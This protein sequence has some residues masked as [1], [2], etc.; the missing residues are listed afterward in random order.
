MNGYSHIIWDWNGTLL[1]DAGW[2]I[3]VVNRMLSA[4]GMARLTG[5]NQYRESFCFP[6]IKYYERVGFDFE[7]EP[8]EELAEEYISLYHSEHHG[9]CGLHRNAVCV[10][11]QAREMGLSQAILSASKKSNLLEQIADFNISGYFD[12]IMG[13]SDIYAKSKIALG[14]D[15]LRRKT[16]GKALL[17][18]DTV[19]DYETAQAI[20]ADCI[21]VASGHQSRQTLLKTGAEVVDDLIDVMGYI[22]VVNAG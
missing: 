5:L 20:N 11:Y 17:V 15:Y 2:C 7:K 10:L 22:K 21:L 19:H 13:L 6:V 9:G 1:D 3:E 14:L 16:V 4:R 18:G 8:F 12:E